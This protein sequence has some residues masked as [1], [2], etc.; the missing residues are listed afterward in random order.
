MYIDPKF[1]IVVWPS[2]HDSTFRNILKQHLHPT[3]TDF[4]IL[5]P[6]TLS[7]CNTASDELFWLFFNLIIHRLNVC[8]SLKPGLGREQ[9]S[10]RNKPSDTI[11]LKN[12]ENGG[13]ATFLHRWSCSP[14]FLIMERKLHLETFIFN[15]YV[16]WY[17]IQKTTPLLL[18]GPTADTLF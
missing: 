14:N 4:N 12:V 17:W 6:T 10:H 13:K 11:L 3:P 1:F 8:A 16:F 18:S 2:T 7:R 9:N 15:L 5:A